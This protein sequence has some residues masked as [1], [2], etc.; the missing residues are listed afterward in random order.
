MPLRTTI[1]TLALVVA[2]GLACAPTLAGPGTRLVSA[3]IRYDGRV[4]LRGSA[5][6]DG[7]ADCD[8][9]W[10]YQRGTLAYAPTDAFA[11]LGVPPHAKEHRL[12]RKPVPRGVAPTSGIEVVVDYGG[13]A[14][15]WSL[16]LVRGAKQPT[17][18]EWYVHPDDVARLFGTRLIAR[19]DAARLQDP[20]R[21]R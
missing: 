12:E 4:I 5:S 21:S 7:S 20:D 14:R 2:L 15:T 9:V 13:E 11:D 18:G 1:T 6:D 8:A 16:R 10:D 19:D 3:E 17:G